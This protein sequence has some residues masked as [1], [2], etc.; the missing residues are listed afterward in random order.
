MAG[1]RSKLTQELQESFC[2][3]IELGLTNRDASRLCGIEERSFYRWLRRGEAAPGGKYGQFCQAIEAALARGKADRLQII[4]DS[5]FG[6]VERNGVR[7][8]AIKRVDH[9]REEGTLD[10]NG[11]FQSTGKAIRE[12]KTDYIPC[13]SADAKWWLERRFPDEFGRTVQ[14]VDGKVEHDHQ[15]SGAV[16]IYRIPDNGRFSPDAGKK[17]GV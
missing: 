11:N 7:Y 13:D 17:D 9:V 4:K 16:T 10:A 14:S 6:A 2:K 1:R 12:S 15:V 3:Y 8:A 5:A